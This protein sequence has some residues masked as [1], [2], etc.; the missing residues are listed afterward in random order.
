MST[1]SMCAVPDR[2]Q[3]LVGEPEAEQVLHGR[4]AQHV[5]NPEHRLLAR[6]PRHLSQQRVKSHRVVQVLA[7]RLFHHDPAARK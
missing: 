3:D 1:C 6:I 2:L 7:E 5:V 4:H